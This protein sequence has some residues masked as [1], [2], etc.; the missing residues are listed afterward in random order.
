[1]YILVSNINGNPK[2]D[3]FNYIAEDSNTF[4]SREDKKYPGKKD[5]SNTDKVSNIDISSKRMNSYKGNLSDWLR[6][7]MITKVQIILLVIN[8]KFFNLYH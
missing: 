4:D 1:M 8:C 6:D 2:R 7:A 3:D 5:A